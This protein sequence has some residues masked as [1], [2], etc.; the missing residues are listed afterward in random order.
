[1][2]KT[3]NT[4]TITT[5]WIERRAG[6]HASQCTMS[7]TPSGADLPDL[8]RSGDETA[9]FCFW[10]VQT[11]FSSAALYIITRYFVVVC[12]LNIMFAEFS[13]PW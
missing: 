1:M 6:Q 3:K 13:V 7:D 11:G 9:L 8:L 2:I 5:S 12:G 4:P 10:T